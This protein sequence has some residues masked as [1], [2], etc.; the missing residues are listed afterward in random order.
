MYVLPFNVENTISDYLNDTKS[1]EEF[2]FDLRKEDLFYL[3]FI[4]KKN[5]YFFEKYTNRFCIIK[6]KKYPLICEFDETFGVMHD[7]NSI[8]E[9]RKEEV[10]DLISYRKQTIIYDNVFVIKFDRKGKVCYHGSSFHIPK[11]CK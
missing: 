3:V 10:T 11:D 8:I 9:K 5:N 7:F 6:D 2:Y 4:S 1:K